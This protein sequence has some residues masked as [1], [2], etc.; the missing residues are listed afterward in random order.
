MPEVNLM[1]TNIKMVSQQTPEFI[2]LK[3]VQY[4]YK[5]SR[6]A[7][8]KYLLFNY[9]NSTWSQCQIVQFYLK[10]LGTLLKIKVQHYAIN[11]CF[12]VWLN[13]Q[14]TILFHNFFQR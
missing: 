12:H 5:D 8:G 7:D 3:N 2:Y 11:V 9:Q 4:F 13:V 6:Q 10:L 14:R 1:W